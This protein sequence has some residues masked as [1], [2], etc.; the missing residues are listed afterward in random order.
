M[1][2]IVDHDVENIVLL[3]ESNEMKRKKLRKKFFNEIRR[4]YL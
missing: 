2:Y 1:G 4:T 3:I